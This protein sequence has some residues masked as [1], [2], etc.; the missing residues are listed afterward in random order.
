M[1]SSL[2]DEESSKQGRA[3]T[4]TQDVQMAKLMSQ[5]SVGRKRIN[6]IVAL[7]PFQIPSAP[8]EQRYFVSR[9]N[10]DLCTS[11]NEEQRN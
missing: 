10:L 5:K 3:F 2:S 7:V 11:Y 1:K 4:K 6:K 8:A 9:G